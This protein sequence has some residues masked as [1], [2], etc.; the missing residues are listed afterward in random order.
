MNYHVEAGT[1][2]EPDT[3]VVPVQKKGWKIDSHVSNQRSREFLC[4]GVEVH[5]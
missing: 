1:K 3:F 5:P 4:Q 2:N